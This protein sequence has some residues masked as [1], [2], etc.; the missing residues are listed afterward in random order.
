MNPKWNNTPENIELSVSSTNVYPDKHIPILLK[1][2][3]KSPPSLLLI[4]DF[5][6]VTKSHP[7]LITSSSLDLSNIWRKTSLAQ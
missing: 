3:E 5:K 4:R 7:F 1:G 6:R 2:D